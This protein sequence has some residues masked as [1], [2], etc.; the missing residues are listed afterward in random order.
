MGD[1]DIPGLRFWCVSNAG[2]IVLMTDMALTLF[3]LLTC[4]RKQNRHLQKVMA[5]L[6]L[7]LQ[8]SSPMQI[9]VAASKD[10]VTVGPF[11]PVLC[12]DSDHS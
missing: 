10:N 7:P 11:L 6:V 4:D 5:Q 1:L 12:V 8:A 3:V 9:S 2:N